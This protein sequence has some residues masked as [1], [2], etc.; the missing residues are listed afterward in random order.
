MP[1]IASVHPRPP[2]GSEHLV[3]FDHDPRRLIPVEYQSCFTQGEAYDLID[4]FL[5]YDKDASGCIDAE[6]VRLQ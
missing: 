5:Y 2:P 3:P 4:R 1:A 6:E